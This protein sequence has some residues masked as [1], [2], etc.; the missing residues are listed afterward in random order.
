M[1]MKDNAPGLMVCGPTD[2]DYRE[3]ILM[4]YFCLMEY[5]AKPSLIPRDDCIICWHEQGRFAYT[6]HC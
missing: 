1:H 6:L 4:C 2:I 5:G 3:R